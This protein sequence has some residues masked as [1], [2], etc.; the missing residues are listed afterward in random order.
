MQ[1]S[2]RREADNFKYSSEELPI[3][4]MHEITLTNRRN[5][6]LFKRMEEQK[7]WYTSKR[8]WTGVIGLIT[9]ISLLVTG[10]KNFSDP[11]VQAELVMTLISL[12]QTIVGVISGRPIAFGSKTFYKK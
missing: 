12:A 10:E 11:A 1:P 8:L 2:S 5:N 9:G 6:Y 7:Q 4:W 3:G